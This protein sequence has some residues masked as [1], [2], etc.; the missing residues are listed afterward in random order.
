MGEQS[1]VIKSI[2]GLCILFINKQISEDAVI[3]CQLHNEMIEV[4]ST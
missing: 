2:E 3:I 4:A 1:K